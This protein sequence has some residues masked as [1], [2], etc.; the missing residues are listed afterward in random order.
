MVIHDFH[1]IRIAVLPAKANAPLLIDA[2]AVLA[3]PVSMQRLKSI[4][5]GHSQRVQ[6]GCGIEHPQF[7]HRH[8]LNILR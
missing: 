4:G 6:V 8:A 3:P 2:Y 7:P 5:R 1:A